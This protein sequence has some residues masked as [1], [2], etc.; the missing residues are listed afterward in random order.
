MGFKNISELE[1]STYL[2]ELKLIRAWVYFKMVQ[3]Y[4]KVPYFEEPLSNYN[5]SLALKEKLD[6]LQTEDY[7]LD[8][9]LSQIIAIDTFELNM[10]EDSPFFTIRFNK[11]T[12]WALQ[13]DIYLWRNNYQYAKIL[14]Y[15]LIFDQFSFY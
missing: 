9:I 14:Y 8:T 10:L 3:I 1:L 4:G 15:Q 13:G 11:F 5:Q 6:S 12:N 7:I 2:A